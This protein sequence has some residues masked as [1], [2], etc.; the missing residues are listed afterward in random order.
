MVKLKPW[1][2]LF[3]NAKNSFQPHLGGNYDCFVIKWSPDGIQL[4][5]TYLGGSDLEVQSPLYD[6]VRLTQNQELVI[7][8]TT[9][10]LD[11]PVTSNAFQ[12]TNK[13][14]DKITDWLHGDLFLAKFSSIGELVLSSYL[15]IECVM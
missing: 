12:K 8:G 15:E 5:G 10:S 2:L 3:A 1:R 4:W 9:V 11:F 14:G 6:Y 13:G 7:L